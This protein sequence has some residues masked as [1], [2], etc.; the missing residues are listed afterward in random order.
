VRVGAGAADGRADDRTGD[1]RQ[2]RS[3]ESMSGGAGF[4]AMGCEDVRSSVSTAGDLGD[5]RHDRSTEATSG[6]AAFVVAGCGD[7]RSKVSMLGDADFVFRNRGDVRRLL[8]PS[9]GAFDLIDLV[10]RDG[11]EWADNDE[12][13]EDMDVSGGRAVG[14]AAVRHVS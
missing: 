2:D 10:G 13:L 6:V 8:V 14:L 12:E 9:V 4:A 7:V 11:T 1:E 3:K 5:E